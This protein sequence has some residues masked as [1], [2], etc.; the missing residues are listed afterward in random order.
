M[1]DL[2]LLPRAN[3]ESDTVCD[4]MELCLRFSNPVSNLKS[5]FRR[6]IFLL[7][8]LSIESDLPGLGAKTIRHVRCDSVGISVE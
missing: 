1:L 7:S 2:F 4:S 6:L 3:C 8:L 5:Q